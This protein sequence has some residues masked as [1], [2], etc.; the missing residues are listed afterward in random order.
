MDGYASSVRLHIMPRIGA[1]GLTDL[2]ATVLEDWLDELDD[3]GLG[4]RGGRRRC[5]RCRSH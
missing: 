1:V 3:D 4:A 5:A 2:T